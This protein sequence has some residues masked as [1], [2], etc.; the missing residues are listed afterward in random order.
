MIKFRYYIT[1]LI[2]ILLGFLAFVSI[3]VLN[4]YSWMNLTYQ[5]FAILIGFIFIFLGIL[6][7]ILFLEEEKKV[8]LKEV[9]IDL[10]DK[11]EDSAVAYAHH[12]KKGKD[13]VK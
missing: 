6:S 7:M 12:K 13:K 2:L 9:D 3:A 11:L 1:G 8:T 10:A 5:I 4:E